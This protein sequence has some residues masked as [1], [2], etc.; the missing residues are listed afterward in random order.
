[1]ISDDIEAYKKAEK[2][3]QE[4]TNVCKAVFWKRDVCNFDASQPIRTPISWHPQSG[5]TVKIVQIFARYGINQ[6]IRDRFG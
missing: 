4:A 1:M 2:W 3:I 6:D 5:C